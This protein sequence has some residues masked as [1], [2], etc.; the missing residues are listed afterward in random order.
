MRPFD[1]DISLPAQGQ[2]MVRMPYDEDNRYWLRDAVKTRRPKWDP[3]VRAWRAPRS[4]VQ[5]IFDQATA[6]GRSARLTRQ[7]KPDTE[8]CTSQCQAASVD[9]VAE[10]TCIC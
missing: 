4:A 5:R 3:D 2:A 8:K 6:D 9:T 7:F 10:C 1:V